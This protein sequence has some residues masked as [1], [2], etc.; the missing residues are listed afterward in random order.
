MRSEPKFE[1]LHVAMMHSLCSTIN[2]PLLVLINV[3][4]GSKLL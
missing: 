4:M 2:E 1:F 3:N